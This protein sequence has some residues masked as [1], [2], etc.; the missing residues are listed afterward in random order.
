[1]GTNDLGQTEDSHL[2]EMRAE[3]ALVQRVGY[4]ASI[5]GEDGYS[6]E[7]DHDVLGVVPNGV[8]TQRYYDARGGSSGID[9]EYLLVVIT[10]RYMHS[11]SYDLQDWTRAI[12]MFRYLKARGDL[13]VS[14]M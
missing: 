1:M 12:H 10:S 3:C 13:D 14:F 6:E 9:A 11:L 8:I 5:N 7:T 2:F 4:I